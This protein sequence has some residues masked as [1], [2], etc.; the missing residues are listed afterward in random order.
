VSSVQYLGEG[1][2]RQRKPNTYKNSYIQYIPMY[3]KNTL[4]DVGPD[5]TWFIAVYWYFIGVDGDTAVN[6]VNIV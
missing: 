2:E 4:T 5:R 6:T 3:N 1:H